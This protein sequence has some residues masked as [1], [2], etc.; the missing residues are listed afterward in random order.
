MIS[1]LTYVMFSFKEKANINIKMRLKEW[2][3]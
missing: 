2:K 1:V 3:F